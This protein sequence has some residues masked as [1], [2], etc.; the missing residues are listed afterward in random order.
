M[1]NTMKGYTRSVS[2]SHALAGGNTPRASRQLYG[3]VGEDSASGRPG[4]AAGLLRL[5]LRRGKL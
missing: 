5:D 2:H 3:A 1:K 4:V